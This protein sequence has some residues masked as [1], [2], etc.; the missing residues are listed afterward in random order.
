[1]I[2]SA[3]VPAAG[4]GTRLLPATRAVPKALLPLVNEPV[5]DII[6]DELE[7]AGITR[8]ILVV[9]EH[10]PILRKHLGDRVEYVRQ[11]E[12]LGLADA[13]ARGA[14]VVDG[15]YVVALGDTVIQ[16]YG[17]VPRLITALGDYDAAIAV[18]DVGLER[19]SQYGIVDADYSPTGATVRG[20]A[21][22]PANPASSLAIAARYVLSGEVEFAS[23]AQMRSVAV[24]LEAQRL[25]VGN[26]DGYAHAFIT[27]YEGRQR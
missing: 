23:L 5:I 26:P 4:L 13:V 25:D 6:L 16:P 18:E 11:P 19:A 14:A 1:V 9:G 20:I 15:P 21:E 2:D 10:E 22:K 27:R 24:G 8:V 17:I 7:D 12:P 3:V